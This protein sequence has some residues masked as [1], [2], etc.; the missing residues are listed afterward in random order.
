MTV[1]AERNAA[2]LRVEKALDICNKAKA[3]LDVVCDGLMFE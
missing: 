3:E 1:G 2:V